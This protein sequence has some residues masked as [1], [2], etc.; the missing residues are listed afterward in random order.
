MDCWTANRELVI[1]FSLI[2]PVIHDSMYTQRYDQLLNICDTSSVQRLLIAIFY[3]FINSIK[4]NEEQGSVH[5]LTEEK[6][7]NEQK[8]RER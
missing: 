1:F 2:L 3:I 6:K 5:M 4:T 7:K 8:E